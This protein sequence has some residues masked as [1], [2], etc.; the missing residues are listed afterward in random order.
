MCNPPKKQ[1]PPNFQGRVTEGPGLQGLLRDAELPRRH[2]PQRL[3]FSTVAVLQEAKAPGFA[4]HRCRQ[5]GELWK[6]TSLPTGVLVSAQEGCGLQSKLGHELTMER[7]PWKASYR[8][9]RWSHT[10][11]I[12]QLAHEHNE[13]IPNTRD[14]RSIE[15]CLLF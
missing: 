8:V 6:P 2:G 7:G 4:R 5:R 15:T 9:Y 10:H 13:L 12:S 1:P 3:R 11:N 14:V